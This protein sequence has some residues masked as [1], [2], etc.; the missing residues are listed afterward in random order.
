MNAASGLDALM[1]VVIVVA[2]LWVYIND[3]DIMMN[4]VARRPEVMLGALCTAS[5]I[6]ISFEIIWWTC[7]P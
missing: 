4:P 3:W 7:R 2:S 1:L 6:L 5:T